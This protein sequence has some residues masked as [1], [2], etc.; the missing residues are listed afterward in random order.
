MKKINYYLQIEQI[1]MLEWLARHCCRPAKRTRIAAPRLAH[2][3]VVEC[4]RIFLHWSSGWL[5]KLFVSTGPWQ[6]RCKTQSWGKTEGKLAQWWSGKES[7]WHWS[8][9]SWPMNPYWNFFTTH[10]S[11]STPSIQL[12]TAIGNKN[13]LTSPIFTTENS[14]SLYK[15]PKQTPYVKTVHVE[16]LAISWILRSGV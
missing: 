14:I 11:L 7:F 9:V 3:C 1:C 15:L 8:A 6:P 16:T 5:C 12:R 13:W 10:S 2:P 4:C